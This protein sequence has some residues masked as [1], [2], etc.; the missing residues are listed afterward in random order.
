M[1]PVLS[2]CIGNLEF[3]ESGTSF[4]IGTLEFYE[5][6]TS[7]CIGTLGYDW[8]SG[9]AFR[10]FGSSLRI[11]IFLIPGPVRIFVLIFLEGTDPLFFYSDPRF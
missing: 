10:F 7:F 2:L 11:R 8:K 9:P 6:G 3:Y 1:N 5:S 4:C